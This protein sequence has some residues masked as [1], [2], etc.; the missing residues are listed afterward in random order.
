MNDWCTVLSFWQ[1]EIT[2]YGFAV[3]ELGKRLY[4][5]P[6]CRSIALTGKIGG[7]TM[8]EI[9]S[10]VA[11]DTCALRGEDKENLLHTLTSFGS[12]LSETQDR[13]LEESVT[14]LKKRTEEQ[15]NDIRQKSAL[16]YKI[17]P[18][19]CGAVIVLCW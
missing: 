13:M 2:A 18:L 15:K 19:L 6:I 16:I 9:V 1:E 10:Y 14:M 7:K 5:H 12:H 3:D 4:T 11:G 8:S 17:A